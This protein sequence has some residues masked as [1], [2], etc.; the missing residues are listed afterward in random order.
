MA[1]SP[2]TRLNEPVTGPTLDAQI[3]KERTKPDDR[4]PID[5]YK[6]NRNPIPYL[7]R[8]TV[9]PDGTEVHFDST[10][11]YSCYE[12]R[13]GSGAVYQIA[14][15]GMET[16]ITVG[17]SHDYKKEGYSLTIDQNGDITI[18]GHSRLSVEGGAHIEIKGNTSLVTTGS[19]TQY[20]GGNLN[21]VVRG[22]HNMQITG[23]YNLTSKDNTTTVR[24]THKTNTTLDTITT[25]GG[26]HS[27]TTKGESKEESKTMIKKADKI[28]LNP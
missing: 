22:D 25:I 26:N 27:T 8:V 13:H 7:N 5:D 23:A 24:G 12:F 20:I 19:M 21:T 3:K 14:D 17:N 2:D 10:P 16:K 28:D 18:N 15:D 1:N 6:K 4:C 11:G 9:Y